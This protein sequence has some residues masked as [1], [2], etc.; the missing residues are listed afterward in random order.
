MSKWVVVTEGF[1]KGK[2]SV[3]SNGVELV[4]SCDEDIAK[5]IV[6][7]VNNEERLIN[8]LAKTQREID[9]IYSI[10]Y[11]NRQRLDS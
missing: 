10:V 2:A 8:D 5:R 9:A 1:K 7:A 4:L 3:E 6:N 11:K